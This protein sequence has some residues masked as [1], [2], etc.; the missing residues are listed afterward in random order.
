M[1]NVEA[2]TEAHLQTRTTR[3]SVQRVLIS[4]SPTM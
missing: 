2:V 1:V 4:V 3:V